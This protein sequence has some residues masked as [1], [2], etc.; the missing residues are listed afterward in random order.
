MNLTLTKTILSKYKDRKGDYPV[1]ALKGENV[2]L[3]G[4]HEN[5]LIVKKGEARFCVQK[6][7]VKI[8]NNGQ[9]EKPE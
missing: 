9:A 1:I 4:D 3:V 7:D 8:S 5:V 6:E 2:E